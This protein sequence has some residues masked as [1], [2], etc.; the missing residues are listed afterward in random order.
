MP[1]EKST[2]S[3]WPRNR[4]A[5]AAVIVATIALLTVAENA[6]VSAYLSSSG[7]FASDFSATALEHK[8]DAIAKQPPQVVFMGDSALWGYGVPAD[9]NAVAL[10]AKGG[11]SCVNLSFK[12][13]SPPNYYALTLL[14]AKFHVHPKLVVLE[15][16]QPSFSP[17]DQSYKTLAPAL[18]ALAG[19]L[20]TP[21][22]RSTLDVADGGEGVLA[23]L[24]AA[25]ASAW[26]VYG[27]RADL[28]DALSGDADAV[29]KERPVAE[30]FLGTYDLAPLDERNVGVR[31]LEAVA[32]ALREQRIPAIAFL[33]PTN[34]AL[35]HEFID[36]PAYARNADYLVKILESRG[37][38]VVDLDRAFPQVDFIDNT[39]LTQRGQQLLAATLA[40]DIPALRIP[41]PPAR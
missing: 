36:V 11:C 15:I 29:P 16:N 21:A 30:D 39:H 31:Y 37:I 1:T 4:L 23:R 18:A 34:H 3:L 28:R 24:G 25:M 32:D 26:L 40:N 14:F 8:L 7:R 41:S 5:V 27:A 9:G 13:G 22:D 19:P 17:G 12:A 33:T 35:V 6:A 20:M 10:L 38:R 2:E